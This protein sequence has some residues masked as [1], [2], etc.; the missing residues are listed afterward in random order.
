MKKHSISYFALFL[1]GILLL[2]SCGSLDKM[3]KAASLIKYEA[4]P[5][6]LELKG[7][8]VSLASVKVSYPGKFFQKKAVMQMTPVL[9]YGGKEIALESF[10]VQGESVEGNN[11]KIKYL[12]GGPYTANTFKPIAY[13]DDMA[14]STLVIK[15]EAWFAGKETKK[16]ALPD[17]TVG[18]GVLNSQKLVMIDPKPI[19]M[20]DKFVRTTSDSYQSEILYMINKADVRAAET[21]KDGIK[22]LQDYIKATQANPAKQLKGIEVSAYASPD[23]PLDLNTD[24]SKDRQKTAADYLKKELKKAKMTDAEKNELWTLLNTPEDW[25]GFKALLEAST[26]KDKEL[27]LRVLS[28]YQDPVVREKEIKNMAATF[29]EIAEQILPQLRRSKI[30]A[31]V[32]VVGHSDEEILALFASNPDSLQLEELLYAGG[33]LATSNEQKLAIYQKAAD[34]FPGCVRAQNNVGFIYVL[35]NKP[36]EAKVAFEKA[37]AIKDLDIVKNN[38]GVVA[39]MQGDLETSGNLFTA[40]AQNVD[41]AN[42]NNGIIQII[43]GNYDVAV[44]YFGNTPEFNTAL[45]K[46]LNKDTDGAMSTL[47][48]VKSDDAKVYYLKAVI[49]ARGDNTEVLFTNLRTAVGK[50]ASL[51]AKAKTDLEFRKYVA[52]EAFKAIVE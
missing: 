20:G 37:Q 18:A 9:Q 35:M 51:K 33:K 52:N 28:M 16:I 49:G 1:A 7:N 2:S 27:V 17:V 47:S 25:D 31:K 46:F 30:T 10:T 3:K 4:S 23:G 19:S 36:A 21:K 6:P 11:P 42:Y 45:A 32:D 39:L 26:I 24:L 13:T 8:D 34:K 43:K 50:D 15:A 38:L 12:E 41:V 44:K 29:E 5:N 48:N 14:T 22:K 40:V